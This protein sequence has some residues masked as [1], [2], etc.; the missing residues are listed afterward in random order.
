MKEQQIKFLLSMRPTPDDRLA[1]SLSGAAP[2]RAITDPV[3]W[4]QDRDIASG[5]N[6]YLIDN[7][8]WYL[9][10]WC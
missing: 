7:H 9:T 5:R 6:N 2:W 3:A 4:Q 8:L 10:Q 1:S